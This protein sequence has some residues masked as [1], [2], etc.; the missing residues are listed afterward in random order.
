V[1]LHAALLYRCGEAG[2]V[3][4]TAQVALRRISKEVLRLLVRVAAA[5]APPRCRRCCNCAFAG[6]RCRRFQACSGSLPTQR[7]LAA[8]VAA[9]CA[10]A[11]RVL[12]GG[13]ELNGG[14]RCS[15]LCCQLADA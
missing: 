1:K 10:D 15:M 4:H 13:S 8:V 11:A 5:F 7:Q 2:I 14:T 9:V 3:P 6:W 12:R